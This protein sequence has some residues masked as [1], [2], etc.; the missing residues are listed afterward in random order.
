MHRWVHGSITS[1]T[2]HSVTYTRPV[3][4]ENLSASSS[5]S[6]ASAYEASFGVFEGPTETINFDYAVYALG[7]G[8]PDPVNVWKPAFGGATPEDAHLGVGTKRSGVRFMERKAESLKQAQRILIVGAGAL[9]IREL[10]K[11]FQHGHS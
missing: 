1:L 6:S 4:K 8:L 7:A 11:F 10:G 9:G 5:S 3:Q 2:S